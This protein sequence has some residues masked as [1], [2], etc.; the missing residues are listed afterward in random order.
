MPDDAAH[1]SHRRRTQEQRSAETRAKLLQATLDSLAEVGYAATTSIAVAERAG[2]SR[3]AQTHHFPTKSELVVAAVDLLGQQLFAELRDRV[4]ALPYGRERIPVALD[5][6]WQGFSSPGY[7]SVV[8]LWLAA[9]HDPELYA[10]LVEAEERWSKVFSDFARAMLG[11][12]HARHVDALSTALSA[13][14]GLGLLHAF[15]PRRHRSTADVWPAHRR[16]L[17]R[18]FDA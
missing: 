8:E 14:R 12:D 17:V 15:E 4:D 3:G 10:T 2:V 1:D 9:A 11:D 18:L 6:I 16:A 7:K 13:I 5:M